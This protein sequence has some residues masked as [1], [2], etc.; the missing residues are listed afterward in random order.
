[1]L[2]LDSDVFTQQIRY[3]AAYIG[4]T[5][6]D[7]F[8]VKKEIFWALNPKFRGQLSRRHKTSKK[9]FVNN[10]EL[11]LIKYWKTLTGVTLRIDESKLHTDS[12]LR[13]PRY[14]GLMEHN[15]IKKE[16]ARLR[17][18]SMESQNDQR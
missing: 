12:D 18:L 4:T 13:Q 8:R 1:M 3:V 6:D 15:K 17:K 9:F 11:E 14:W 5:C 16:K 7:W 2:P 10:F